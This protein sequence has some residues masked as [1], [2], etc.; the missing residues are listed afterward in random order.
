MS[1]VWAGLIV[2]YLTPK[3]RPNCKRMEAARSNRQSLRSSPTT[4][5]D[6]IS[7]SQVESIEEEVVPEKNKYPY[8]PLFFLLSTTVGQRSDN[9]HV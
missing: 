7:S 6:E 8:V 4:V 9:S 2:F 1:P 3:V 5:T